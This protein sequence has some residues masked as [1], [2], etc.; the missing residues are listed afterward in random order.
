MPTS[1]NLKQITHSTERPTCKL[2]RE[3]NRVNIERTAVPATFY[4]EENKER[5]QVI[6]NQPGP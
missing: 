6:N 2:Y 1:F 5:L 3:A 4:I